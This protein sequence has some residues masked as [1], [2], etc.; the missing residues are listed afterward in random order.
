M[1]FTLIYILF[2]TKTF[3]KTNKQNCL[4]S[5]RTSLSRRGAAATAAAISKQPDVTTGATYDLDMNSTTTT[6]NNSNR[7]VSSCSKKRRPGGSRRRA[8]PAK[9]KMPDNYNK[10]G[11]IGSSSSSPR[12]EESANFF[13]CRLNSTLNSI[14]IILQLFVLFFKSL[15]KISSHH[16]NNSTTANNNNN[17]NNNSS[18]ISSTVNKKIFYFLIW[19]FLLFGVIFVAF[20]FFH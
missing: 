13:P 18:V 7:Y 19:L 6:N 2:S 17:N 5:T 15:I 9:R 12:L 20:S 14:L 16:T 1:N 4:D 3:S 10:P 11:Q 8:G